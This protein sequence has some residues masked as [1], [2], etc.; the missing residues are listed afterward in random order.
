MLNSLGEILFEKPQT[1]AHPVFAAQQLRNFLLLL[2]P[3][4]LIGKSCCNLTSSF[5]FGT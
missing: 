1:L 3:L 5:K 4:L 2:F